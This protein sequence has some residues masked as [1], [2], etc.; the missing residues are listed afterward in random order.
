[1]IMSVEKGDHRCSYSQDNKNILPEKVG[2]IKNTYCT[3]TVCCFFA[4]FN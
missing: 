3:I 2:G 4:M 1:M